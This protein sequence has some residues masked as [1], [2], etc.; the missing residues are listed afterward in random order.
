MGRHRRGQRDGVDAVVGEHLVEV[1]G[2]ARAGEHARRRARGWLRRRRSTTRA[3]RPGSAREVARDVRTP[4]AQAGDGD[5]Q[6]AIG[7]HGSPESRSGLTRMPRV[8]MD[9]SSPRTSPRPPSRRPATPPSAAVLGDPARADR[10]RGHARLDRRHGGGRPPRLRLR[11]RHAHR[12]GLAGR[13]GA[14][15]GRARRRLHGARR[16]AARVGAEP[17]RPPARRPRLRARPDGS[18]LRARRP[19]RAPHVPLRRPRPGRA[20]PAHAQPAAAPSGTADRRRL[21][22]AVPRAH[23]RGGGRR[24]GRHPALG[25]RGG[26]GRHRRAASRRSGWRG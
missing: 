19:H 26:V 13:P 8:G 9:R 6:W 11:G 14:A 7:G 5:A 15:R 24:G 12:D 2:E 10:L 3:R 17:A 23:A 21:R 1:A 25:R 18:R 16:P 4:V 22:A 20:R